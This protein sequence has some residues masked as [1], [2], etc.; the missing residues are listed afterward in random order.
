MIGC[1]GV[2][3]LGVEV[4]RAVPLELGADQRD[5]LRAS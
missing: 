5:V 3:D 4:A 1:V 2:D